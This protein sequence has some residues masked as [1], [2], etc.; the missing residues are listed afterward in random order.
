MVTGSQGVTGSGDKAAAPL[1]KAPTRTVPERQHPSIFHYPIEAC[2]VS[3]KVSL[4]TFREK[5]Q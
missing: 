4:E 2:D 5:L 3:D 1:A